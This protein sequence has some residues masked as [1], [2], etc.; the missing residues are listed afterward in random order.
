MT[1]I[2]L[3]KLKANIIQSNSGI[4]YG[5]N[6]QHKWIRKS[7]TSSGFGTIDGDSNT[8]R[9]NVSLIDKRK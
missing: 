5:V 9:N 8:V 6:V 2:H 4:Y 1:N 3:K 7:T